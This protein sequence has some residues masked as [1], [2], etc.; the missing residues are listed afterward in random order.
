MAIKTVTNARTRSEVKT[1]QNATLGGAEASYAS[2]ENTKATD[3]TK[4]WTVRIV[5]SYFDGTNYCIVAE[6]TYPEINTDPTG[7]VPEAAPAD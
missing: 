4:T 6:G 1:I 5:N 7:Q 2:Y 3:E